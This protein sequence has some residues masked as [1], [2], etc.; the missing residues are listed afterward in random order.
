MQD[1]DGLRMAQGG[2]VTLL[3]LV[4]DG[5]DTREKS[6]IMT[7]MNCQTLSS[8]LKPDTFHVIHLNVP[9]F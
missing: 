7:Q 4:K 8:C 5:I 3:L 6:M 9:K 1:L 2:A